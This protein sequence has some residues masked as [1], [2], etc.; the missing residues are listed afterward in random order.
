[1]PATSG[2][3]VPQPGRARAPHTSAALGSSS[4][5]KANVTAPGRAICG[6]RSTTA[7]GSTNAKLPGANVAMATSTCWPRKKTSTNEVCGA[8]RSSNPAGMLVR[9]KPSSGSGGGGIGNQAATTRP[10]QASASRPTVAVA[11]GPPGDRATCDP[12]RL[13]FARP[14][15]SFRSDQEGQGSVVAPCHCGAQVL[16][17]DAHAYTLGSRLADEA[18]VELIQVRRAPLAGERDAWIQLAPAA[19]I[20]VSR[21]ERASSQGRSGARTRPRSRRLWPRWRNVRRGDRER[22]DRRRL[23]ELQIRSSPQTGGR[24]GR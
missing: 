22:S 12:S 8:L 5:D 10:T 24:R 4:P 18:T 17:Q 7:S 3:K 19:A 20:V 21:P 11:D 14:R 23:P 2:S 15:T 13:L 9:N 1:M 6:S 16:R